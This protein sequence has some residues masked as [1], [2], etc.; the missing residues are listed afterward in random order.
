MFIAEPLPYFKG[1]SYFVYDNPDTFQKNIFTITINFKP[2][3]E[4]GILLYSGNKRDFIAV[5]L[6]DG[7]IEYRYE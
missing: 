5:A 6:K 4:N 7:A 1:D 3:K 2:Y